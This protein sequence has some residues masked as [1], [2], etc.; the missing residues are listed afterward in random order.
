VL[1]QPLP[2][3][4]I[5]QLLDELA[6]LELRD[7]K[8][9]RDAI[10]TSLGLVV[11]FNL[12]AALQVTRDEW[13]DHVRTG[14]GFAGSRTVAAAAAQFPMLQLRNPSSDTRLLVVLAHAGLS[15]NGQILLS[16]H[17]AALA[18]LNVAGVNLRQGGAASVGDL[19]QDVPAGLV[20]TAIDRVDVLARTHHR[21]G[22]VQGALIAELPPGEGI[23]VQGNVAASTLNVG[24][25]WAEVPL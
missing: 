3:T 25:F 19:I 5:R 11:E 9:L 4:T 21:W 1:T 15:V 20:G 16:A 2:Q 10:A 17:D 24:F 8:Q 14:R 12:A 23:V 13:W 18:G 6:S 22:G 7:A